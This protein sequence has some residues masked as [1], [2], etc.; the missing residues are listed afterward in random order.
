MFRRVLTLI[1]AALLAA[2][3]AEQPPPPSAPASASDVVLRST[4]TVVRGEV[5]RNATLD[6]MLR[7][8]GLASEAVEQ[9]VSVARTV[10]DPRRLRSLQ[11]YALAR[12]LDG[13]LKYF[14]YEIDADSFLRIAPGADR[15]GDLHAEVLPIPKTLQHAT[16]SGSIDA[17]TPSLFESIQSA[18]ETPVLA[19]AL[20]QAAPIAG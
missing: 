2:C 16:V 19:M 11:P 14:E 17:D 7:Q 20:A 10:F 12:T 1:P 8:H 13:A 18:G 9:I 5:P 6:G 3:A 15:T 4:T